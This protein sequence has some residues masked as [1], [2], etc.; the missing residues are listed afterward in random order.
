MKLTPY[1][2]QDEQLKARLAQFQEEIDA[3]E[4][5]AYLALYSRDYGANLHYSSLSAMVSAERADFLR[6]EK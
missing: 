5:A 6:G 3:H 2:I 4:H 1:T